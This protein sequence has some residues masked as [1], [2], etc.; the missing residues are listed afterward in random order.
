M[1]WREGLLMSLTAIRCRHMQS[2]QLSLKSRGTLSSKGSTASGDSVPG[3][4][5]IRTNAFIRDW[6][7]QNDCLSLVHDGKYTRRHQDHWCGWLHAYDTSEEVH[8]SQRQEGCAWRASDRA[9][10]SNLY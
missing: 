4:M 10:N 9:R 8:W 5:P 6:S 3:A 2:L 1:L 7:S